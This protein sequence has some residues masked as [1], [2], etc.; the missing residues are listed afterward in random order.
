MAGPAL[1]ANRAEVEAALAALPGSGTPSFPG[2]I[3]AV[4]DR[5]RNPE[6]TFLRI[7]ENLSHS[8]E[9]RFAAFYAVLLRLRREER[10]TDYT[11]LLNQYEHTFGNEPYFHTFRA[12][13]LRLEGSPTSLLQAIEH[14]RQA[15]RLIPDVAGVQ[16]QL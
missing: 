7:C 8:E 13:A 10:L 14:S 3:R 11:R 4:I 15:A 16:H 5:T 2:E 12:V 1:Y 9:V 6:R